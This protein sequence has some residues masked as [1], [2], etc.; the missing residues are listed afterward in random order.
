MNVNFICFPIKNDY[1]Q[2]V[3][4]ETLQNNAFL[5]E[6]VMR[7]VCRWHPFFYSKRTDQEH[8]SR[9]SEC[10]ISETKKIVVE[11]STCFQ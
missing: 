2:N 3:V 8:N 1:R 5:E 10:Q 7:F 11:S 4:V 6:I 9:F